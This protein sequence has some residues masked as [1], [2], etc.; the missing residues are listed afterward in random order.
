[1]SGTAA[2]GAAT[3]ERIP[4]DRAIE[5]VVPNLAVTSH[6]K[7]SH[8]YASREYD[9]FDTASVDHNEDSFRVTSLIVTMAKRFLLP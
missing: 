9:D 1:L 7:N 3:A 5:P 2:E 4:N 6:V 8:F